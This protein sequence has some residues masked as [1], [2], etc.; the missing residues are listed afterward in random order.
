MPTNT[1]VSDEIWVKVLAML[2][3]NWC[4]IQISHNHVTLHFFDDHKTI[5]DTMTYSTLDKA[6]A[7]LIKNRFIPISEAA[8]IAGQICNDLPFTEDPIHPQT[9]IY[10]S[11]EYWIEPNDG[12][13]IIYKSFIE[14]NNHPTQDQ[15]ASTRMAPRPAHF[16][17]NNRAEAFERWERMSEQERKDAIDDFRK[18]LDRIREERKLTR[19]KRRLDE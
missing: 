6:R 12:D 4:K 1:A 9:G 16:E 13:P 17:V 2:Q 11:G 10:S 5:F 3:Q 19:T 14:K 18:N 8:F 15:K 7:A